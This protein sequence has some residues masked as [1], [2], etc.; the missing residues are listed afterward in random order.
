MFVFLLILIKTYQKLS[1]IFGIIR[2]PQS[3]GH[4]GVTYILSEILEQ[5]VVEIWYK[6][7]PPN[8]IDALVL[9]NGVLPIY[10]S[11]EIKEVISYIKEFSENGGF[12]LGIGSG[13]SLLCDAGLLPGK[14]VLSDNRQ[15]CC[16]NA[17]VRPKHTQSAITA[18]L[19]TDFAYKVPVSNSIG[20]YQ[21]DDETMR[22]MR[23]NRQV[24]FQYCAENGHLS[25]HANPNGSRANIAAICNQGKNVYGMVPL[26]ELAS[27]DEIGNTDGFHIFESII[28]YLK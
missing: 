5:E 12:V 25:E 22:E 8:K 9:P 10:L 18:L 16:K 24:L 28:A 26:P 17:F 19:N 23:E 6:G 3:T 2:F 21:V 1:M 27:D 15:F 20:K 7:V 14:L 13:F 4:T 11:D